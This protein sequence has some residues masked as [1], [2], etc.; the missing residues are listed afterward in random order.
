MHMIMIFLTL[1]IALGIRLVPLP[2]T[3]WQQRWQVGLWRFALPPILITTTAIALVLM[4]TQGLMLGLPT[5][6]VSYG[7]GLGF[8]LLVIIVMVTRA[9][10]AVQTINQVYKLPQHSFDQDFDRD[11]NQDFNHHLEGQD[12]QDQGFRL[13]QHPAIFA[14]QIGIWQPQLVISQGLLD[15]F[16]FEHFQAVLYHEQAHRQFQDNFWFWGLGCLH[17]IGGWLPNSQVLWQ[18]LLLLRE[19]RADQWAVKYVAP[20]TLAE[21][22][23]W[24]VQSMYSPDFA[25]DFGDRGDRLELRIETILNPQPILGNP[26]YGWF[27]VGLLP[28]LTVLLHS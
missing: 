6:G 25:A 16:D 1:V 9:V 7:L 23:L 5:D 13:W 10:Q 19:I 26:S 17:Q 12:W 15:R 24:S 27:I 4:G 3:T 18:E 28:L 11:F 22:L 14:A 20:L 21:A 8:C 2:A